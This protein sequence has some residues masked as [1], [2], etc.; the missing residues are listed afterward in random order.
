MN[1]RLLF[2]L[3]LVVTGVG[4]T[5]LLVVRTYL[6]R[7][8]AP[9]I[10]VTTPTPT[11]SSLP[12]DCL[13]EVTEVGFTVEERDVRYGIHTRNDCP[14]ALVNA[15]VK[16]EVL[17]GKG[18]PVAGRD[19]Y[20]PDLTVLLPGQQAEAGG[21]FYLDKEGPVGRVE[22]SFTSG[23]PA[24]AEVFAGWPREVRVEDLTVS[25][26][27]DRGRS[28]VTGLMVTEP[29]G[30]T[31]CSPAASLILRNRAGKIIYGRQVFIKADRVNIDLVVPETADP[32][33][34]TVFVSQGQDA[35]SFN[36]IPIAAC[37]A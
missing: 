3:V 15:T 21:Y 20:L 11:V 33:R 12:D 6:E 29:A 37:A 16:V 28:E 26:P 32:A 23:T 22:A 5:G 1:S 19:Q 7:P 14:Y 27:D 31:P 35:V 24:P 34:T 8:E 30:A 2:W 18:R 17:D 13:P 4:L 36:P 9:P 10:I 25:A